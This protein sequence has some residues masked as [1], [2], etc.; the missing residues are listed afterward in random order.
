MRKKTSAAKDFADVLID[1]MQDVAGQYVKNAPFDKIVWGTVSEVTGSTYTITIH[2][3]S[4]I[5]TPVL[6]SAGVI[7]VGD[8]V[9][10]IVPNNNMPNM[11]ILGKIQK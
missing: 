4:Y 1:K 6:T 11:F 5:N 8:T 2:G 9:V 3:K 10:C 7:S